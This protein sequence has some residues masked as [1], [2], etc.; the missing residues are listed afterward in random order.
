VKTNRFFVC[1][2]VLGA[3]LT[4]CKGKTAAPAE[5]EPQ[6]SATPP[7]GATKLVRDVSK[8]RD[9]SKS[10]AEVDLS[11]PA[12][13]GAVPKDAKHS[14][15]GLA[16]IVLKEGTGD[17]HPRPSEYVEMNYIGWTAKGEVIQESLSYGRPGLVAVATMFP[18]LAEGLPMMVVG[19]KRRFWIPSKLGF[20]E[21]APGEP[22]VEGVPPK[23]M[24]VYD[25]EIV[26]IKT[27]RPKPPAP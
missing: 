24:L 10:G 16:W 3:A 9:G 5:P 17:A 1:C 12:N 25:I 4:A 2:V 15:S 22:Q 14:T 18:G 20:G 11:A 21:A 7:G 19:E 27:E 23:G 13:V 8:P 6:S 26:S